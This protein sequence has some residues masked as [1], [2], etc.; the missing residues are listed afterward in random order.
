MG[1]PGPHDCVWPAPLRRIRKTCAAYYN[2][3]R[4]YL[5]LG[6]DTANFRRSETVGR[7][8]AIRVLGGLHHQ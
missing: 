3:V 1:T 2:E 5:S 7:I 6:K 8:V 4:T